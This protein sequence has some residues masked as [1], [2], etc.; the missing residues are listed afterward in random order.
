MSARAPGCEADRRLRQRPRAAR[1]RMRR[2]ACGRSSGRRRLRARCARDACSRWPY[3]S[4]R[5]SSATPTSTLESVPTPNAAAG[6]EEFARRKDAVAE[7]GFGD[8]AEAG[9]RAGPRDALR[10]VIRHVGG[11]D[12]APALIDRRMLQ[13]PFDRPRPDQARQSSTSFICSAAWM[14][15][16]PPS[17]SGMIAASSSGVTARRLCGA[18]PTLAPGKLRSPCAMRPSARR[19]D[20]QSR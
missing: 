4:W 9:H 17:A 14:C 19:T 8:G 10:F 5:S 6:V 12:E 11:V 16:G 20:R 13:Q 15:T 3:S 1:E 7:A 2:T 18:M